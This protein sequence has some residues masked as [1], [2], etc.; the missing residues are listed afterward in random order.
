VVGIGTFA[1]AAACTAAVGIAAGAIAVEVRTDYAA[2][3][4]VGDSSYM[5]AGGWET[6]ARGR[7]SGSLGVDGRGERRES[8][9]VVGRAGHLACGSS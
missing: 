9:H 6:A 2:S 3:N 5:A 1:S 4:M 8:G 7:R